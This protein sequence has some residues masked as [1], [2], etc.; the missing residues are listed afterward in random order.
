MEEVDSRTLIREESDLLVDVVVDDPE[1][2]LLDIAD[3]RRAHGSSERK[4]EDVVVAHR[5]DV[6]GRREPHVDI[7]LEVERD[8]WHTDG[9]HAREVVARVED[10]EVGRGCQV[11]C[12]GTKRIPDC[13]ICSCFQSRDRGAGVEDGATIPV[14]IELEHRR[15][16]VGE[17]VAA[18][19]DA[20][21][22]HVIVR[23]DARIP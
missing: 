6:I 22:L 3:D 15:W 12:R 16:D 13:C 10:F 5:D 14:R 23:C 18:N 7:A 21:Y 17:Q 1:A 9:I 11:H 20:R 19:A 4:A 2:L 8:G